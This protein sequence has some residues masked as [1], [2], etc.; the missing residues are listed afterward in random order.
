MRPP[1][2][3]DTSVLAF[4]RGNLRICDLCRNRVHWPVC[5]RLSNDNNFL[6]TGTYVWTDMQDNNHNCLLKMF[7]NLDFYS[8]GKMK[9]LMTR[10]DI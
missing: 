1:A 5:Y 4:S 6:I 10:V 3:L 9:Q 7:A 2:L 8:Y